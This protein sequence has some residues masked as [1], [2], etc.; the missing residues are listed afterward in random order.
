M[1]DLV[2]KYIATLSE[3]EQVTLDIASKHFGS[4]F[5]IKISIGFRDWLKKQ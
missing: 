1:P 5:D 2:K 4:S 3:K